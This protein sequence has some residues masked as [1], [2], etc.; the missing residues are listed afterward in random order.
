MN[1][2]ISKY[3]DYLDNVKHYSK[4]T[5]ASYSEDL[6]HFEKYLLENHLDIEDV[7][8]NIIQDYLYQQLLE[9]L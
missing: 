4:R 1:E 3:I 5:V 9:T 8:E 7:N 2:S 6:K